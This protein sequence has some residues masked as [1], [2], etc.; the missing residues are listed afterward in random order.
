MQLIDRSYFVGEL[1]I[2]PKDEALDHFILKYEAQF[3]A[4]ALGWGFYQEF[5]AAV[6]ASPS[7]TLEQRWVDLRDGLTYTG[8]AQYPTLW[9]GLV[10]PTTKQSPIANYVYYWW[11]RDNESQSASM[12]EKKTAAENARD[13]TPAFKGARAWNEMVD[14]VWS[15]RHY[16]SVQGTT[17]YPNW[18]SRAGTYWKKI[19][20]L[21][22]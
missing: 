21:G 20:V 14:Q 1:L 16:L 17:V 18:V 4:N 15:L 13:W 3:L 8:I 19:N 12:G 10:N 2:Y 11:K 5:A 22:I 6:D 7:V 9:R